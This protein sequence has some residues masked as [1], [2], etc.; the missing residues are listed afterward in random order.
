MPDGSTIRIIFPVQYATTAVASATCDNLQI[1]HSAALVSITPTG[2]NCTTSTRTLTISGAITAD[3]FVYSVTLT[4][5][6]VLNPSP[7]V[8]TD[9]FLGFVGTDQALPGSNAFVRLSPATF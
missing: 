7:A 1:V 4:L 3:L 6:G 9:N 8:D 2:Y 5:G